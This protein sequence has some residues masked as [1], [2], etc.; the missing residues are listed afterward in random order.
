MPSG[1]VAAAASMRSQRGREPETRDAHAE[2][3]AHRGERSLGVPVG[4]R[5]LQPPARPLRPLE[6]DQPRQQPAGD[7]VADHERRAE[8]ERGL[9]RPRREARPQRG[10]GRH[11][12]TQRTSGGGPGCPWPRPESGAQETVTAVQTVITTSP[13][14]RP[15]GARCRQR[16]RRGDRDHHHQRPRRQGG[17]QSAAFVEVNRQRRRRGPSGRP[18]A[19]RPQRGAPRGAWGRRVARRRAGI[20]RGAPRRRR[21]AGGAHG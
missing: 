19:P 2:D 8:P 4:E 7:A 5:L 6:L 14:G 12:R 18:V 1:T 13:A 3:E 10:G 11:E 9:H 16:M 20:G 17:D 15:A 21:D